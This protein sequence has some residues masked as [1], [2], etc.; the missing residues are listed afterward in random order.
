[1]EREMTENAGEI[2][3]MPMPISAFVRREA[4]TR[5]R[6]TC[7]TFSCQMALQVKK[8]NNIFLLTVITHLLSSDWFA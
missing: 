8:K 1:M 2:A 4:K 5:H 7:H 3:G 6:F